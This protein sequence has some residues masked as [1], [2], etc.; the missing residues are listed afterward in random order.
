M[1]QLSAMNHPDK[2][3]PR[4]GNEH[5]HKPTKALIGIGLLIAFSLLL[6]G[7]TGKASEP[8]AHATPVEF[9]AH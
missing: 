8:P 7:I 4:C 9:G 1:P 3:H 6:Y 5:R 2:Y